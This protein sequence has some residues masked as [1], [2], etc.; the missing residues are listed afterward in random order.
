M[1]LPKIAKLGSSA[2]YNSVRWLSDRG[3]VKDTREKD[4]PRRRMINLTEKGKQ[5]AELIL[6]VEEEL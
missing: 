2:V 1:S 3:L 5:V 6:R 4:A